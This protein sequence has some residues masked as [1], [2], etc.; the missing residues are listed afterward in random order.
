MGLVVL[1]TFACL[2]FGVGHVH[3]AGGTMAGSRIHRV[4]MHLNSGEEQV[5]KARL[6]NIKNLYE[7]MGAER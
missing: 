4:V 2:V 5:Q 3:S 1:V 6:N 7:A